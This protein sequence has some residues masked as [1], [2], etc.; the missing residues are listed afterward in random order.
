[1]AEGQPLFTQQSQGT[2]RVLPNVLEV[3]LHASYGD[4]EYMVSYLSGPSKRDLQLAR[5]QG[6]Y[7][8]ITKYPT[9]STLKSIYRTHLIPCF[10]FVFLMMKNLSSD[11]LSNTDKLV[12]GLFL[13]GAFLCHMF[14]TA[15]HA[16]SCHSERV[17]KFFQKYVSELFAEHSRPMNKILL[18]PI[19]TSFSTLRKLRRFVL[20]G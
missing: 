7:R 8:L 11:H 10:L 5:A 3:V 15:F 20:V 2:D 19:R 1:M 13:L 9:H 4:H 14:S 6:S 12:I 18:C 17:G 16:F